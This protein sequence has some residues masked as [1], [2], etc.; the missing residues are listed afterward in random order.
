MNSVDAA[1]CYAYNGTTSRNERCAMGATLSRT[2]MT[3]FDKLETMEQLWDDLCRHAAEVP[4]PLWHRDVLDTREQRLAA[5]TADF[6]EWE[7]AKEKIRDAMRC[8]SRFSR[9]PHRT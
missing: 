4:S 7:T 5:G 6:L 2:E 8:R 3:L 1:G 9:Q